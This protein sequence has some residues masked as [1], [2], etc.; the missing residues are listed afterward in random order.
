MPNEVCLPRLPANA[1]ST[2]SASS[3]ETFFSVAIAVPI[4]CT[5]RASMCFSTAAASCSPSERSSTDARCAPV[6]FCG[7]AIFAHPCFHD[8]RDLLRIL[9][10]DALG[11]FDLL[12]EPE[13][14]RARRA[15]AAAKRQRVRDGLEPVRTGARE[16]KLLRA[17]RADEIA[18]QRSQ[19]D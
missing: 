7:S 9:A 19:H 13:R 12:L 16:R 14:R 11:Q 17:R 15:H 8:L 5:S 18:E 10:R 6:S 1:S 3:R 2:A 4:A